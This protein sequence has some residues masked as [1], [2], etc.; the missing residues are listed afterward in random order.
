MKR[1]LLIGMLIVAAGCAGIRTKSNIRQAGES[2]PDTGG[3][4]CMLAGVPPTAVKYEV[5]GKI[6]ATKG[7]YG[8]PNELLVPM[9]AEARKFGADAIID[10]RVGQRFKGPLPWR[11]VAPTGTGRA[12][13]LLQDSASLDCQQ[14]GGTLVGPGGI[15]PEGS[16]EMGRPTVVL[17]GAGSAEQQ[18]EPEAYPYTELMKLD[19]LRKKGIL[20]E[21]EFD[22]TK[23]RVID[24]R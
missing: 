24:A 1:A 17:D 5:L 14:L 3:N 4:V 8:S 10:V 15:L 11:T 23:Q 13:R 7:S 12:I 16:R 9:A 18:T 21:E 6:A 22:A 2:P 19:D 20:T